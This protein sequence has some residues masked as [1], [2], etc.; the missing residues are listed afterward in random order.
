MFSKY[1]EF[2]IKSC[3]QYKRYNSGVPTYLHNRPKSVVAHIMKRLDSAAN[4]KNITRISPRFFTVVSGSEKYQKEDITSF[5]LEKFNDE[6]QERAPLTRSTLMAI[7]W[8]R[9]KSKSTDLFFTPAVCM[10][11]AVCLKNR[12]RCMTAVQ[13]IISLMLQHSGFMATLVRLGAL[14]LTVSHTFLY[15]KLDEYGENHLKLI[16]DQVLQDG[17]GL[18]T[19]SDKGRRNLG[20]KLVVDNFNYTSQ[21]HEMTEERQNTVVNWVG[22]M[23]TEN[24]IF[25]DRLSSEKPDIQKLLQMDNALCLPNNAEHVRQRIDYITLCARL[26]VKHI[27]SLSGLE[28]AETQHIKHQ[29]SSQTCERT[30]TVFGEMIYHNENDASGMQEVM[31]HLHQYVPCDSGDA[32]SLFGE[33]GVVGDQLTIERGVS[34]LLQLE[35]GFTGKERL[36]GLHMEVADFH[37]GMK[38][39]QVA[40]DC[41]Y[42]PKALT[43]RCTMFSDK[44]LVNRRDINTDVSRRYSGCKKFFLLEV[45]ARVIAGFCEVLGIAS[46]DEVPSEQLLTRIKVMTAR[47]KDEYLNRISA[48]VVDKFIIRNVRND[49]M[50]ES[51]EYEDWLVNTNVKNSSGQFLCRFKSCTQTFKYDKSKRLEHEKMHGLHKELSSCIKNIPNDDMFNYQCSLLD[52]GMVVTNFFDAVSEGD[53]SRVIRSWKF[54]LMYLRQDGARSRK[55]A[56]EALYLLCQIYALLSPRDAHSLVWNRFNK[57]KNG[58][59]GNIPLDLALE[60]YNNLLKNVVRKLGPNSTNPKVIDRFCKALSVNKKLLENFDGSCAVIKRSGEHVA[61]NITNELKKIVVELIKN[62]AMQIRQGRKFEVLRDIKP[63]LLED[64]DVHSMYKWIKDH[65]EYIRL[66]KAG[67]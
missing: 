56:L 66:H 11:A 20:R 15:K 47:E 29:Y 3:N 6:L 30:E 42:N 9:S 62:N 1:K 40:Y 53:G 65:K 21:P 59:G 35:N 54:M 24:R 10:A 45:Q 33:Q 67:R 8:R 4:L 37:G 60:H 48:A 22:L 50:V 41:L 16:K 27:K 61:A 32:P 23:I 38:F 17:L 31:T 58:K 51:Q 64:F 25:N 36:D 26:A 43:D 5:T 7:S 18:T 34:T 13:L 46:P 63:S 28:S 57:N 55:Y 49:R 14:R 19:T 2:N 52:I 12:S 44:V 39:L